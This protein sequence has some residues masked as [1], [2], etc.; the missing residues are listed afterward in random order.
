MRVFIQQKFYWH[1]STSIQWGFYTGV[2]RPSTQQQALI[3]YISK[4]NIVFLYICRPKTGKRVDSREWALVVGR[5]RPI[6][7]VHHSP[8]Y[9]LPA[10][11]NTFDVK[12]ICVSICP[13]LLINGSFAPPDSIICASHRKKKKFHS[14]VRADRRHLAAATCPLHLHASAEW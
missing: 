2:L 14:L 4:L 1:L 12:L 3:G 9:A 10:Q 5:L 13:T 11:A 8:A 7:A 6:Q